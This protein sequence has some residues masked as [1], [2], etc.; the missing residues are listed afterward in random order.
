MSTPKLPEILEKIVDKV[1][2]YHPKPKLQAARKRKKIA[3][4]VK[5]KNALASPPSAHKSEAQPN[6]DQA[7]DDKA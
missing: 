1:F 5:R 4:T 6:S 3:K 7:I 2:A